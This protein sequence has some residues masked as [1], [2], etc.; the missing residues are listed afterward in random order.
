M[1]TSASLF[2]MFVFLLGIKGEDK[3]QRQSSFRFESALLWQKLDLLS[4]QRWA[5]SQ[6]SELSLGERRQKNCNPSHLKYESEAS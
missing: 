6:V 5:F 1:N 4:S 3:D 2:S